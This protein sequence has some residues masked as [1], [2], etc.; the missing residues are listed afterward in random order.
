MWI[1]ARV[2]NQGLGEERWYVGRGSTIADTKRVERAREFNSFQ[3]AY[4]F[5]K[6][7]IAR[8]GYYKIEQVIVLKD[9]KGD[10]KIC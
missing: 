3:E 2:E 1:I 8:E 7:D 9:D 6:E 5:L 10:L 4:D